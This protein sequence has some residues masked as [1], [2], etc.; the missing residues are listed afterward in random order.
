MSRTDSQCTQDEDLLSNETLGLYRSF[1][2]NAHKIAQISPYEK[3]SRDPGRTKKPGK[4]TTTCFQA[5]S[6]MSGADS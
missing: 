2:N 1:S 3:P 5:S 4:V 6:G